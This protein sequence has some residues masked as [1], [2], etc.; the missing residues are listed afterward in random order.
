MKIEVR[1]YATLRAYGPSRETA[2]ILEV[3]EKATVHEVLVRLGIPDK[4]QRIV[5]VNGRPAT[6]DSGL[7]EGDRLVLFPPAAGG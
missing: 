1:R 7:K 5:L 4:V 6:E 3:P 2:S